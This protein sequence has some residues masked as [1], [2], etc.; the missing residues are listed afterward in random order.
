MWVRDFL[1]ADLEDG[2]A[3]GIR[4]LTYGYDSTLLAN[5]SNAGVSEFARSFLEAIENARRSPHVRTP[6]SMSIETRADRG[7]EIRRPIVFVGHSLGGIV[8]KQVS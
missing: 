7:Q 3:G 1:G 5:N 8:V 6:P 2:V 4:I